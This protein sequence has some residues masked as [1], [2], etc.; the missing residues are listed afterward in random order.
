MRIEINNESNDKKN[1]FSTKMSDTIVVH[2]AV[3]MWVFI[4]LVV[5]GERTRETSK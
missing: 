1:S 3:D 4:A 5:G 2:G